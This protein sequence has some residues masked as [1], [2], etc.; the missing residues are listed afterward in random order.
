[1]FRRFPSS[2]MQDPTLVQ[3]DMILLGQLSYTLQSV[4]CRYLITH[5]PV[6]RCMTPN[7]ALF[8][9]RHQM[10]RRILEFSYT[11]FTLNLPRISALVRQILF[12]HS[13]LSFT[14][15]NLVNLVNSFFTLYSFLI[16]S[17]QD[18]INH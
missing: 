18:V 14:L 5:G 9:I 1:M 12:I 2:T 16:T 7:T 4:V 3:P 13:F 11:F 17:S 6:G 10:N 15:V 8:F